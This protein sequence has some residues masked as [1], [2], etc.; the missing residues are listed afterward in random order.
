MKGF[1]SSFLGWIVVV[2]VAIVV[3]VFIVWS[4]VPDIIANNLSKKLKVSVEID[5]ISLSFNQIDVENLEVSNVPGGILQKAFSTEQILV[6]APLSRYLDNKIEIDEIDLNNVYLGLEFESSKSTKGNWTTIMNN[7]NTSES[8]SPKPKKEEKKGE[9][10]SV[11]IRTL[12]LTNIQVD[13]VYVKDGTPV[14]RLPPIDRIVLKNISSEEGVP[15][16]QIMKSVLGQMLQSVFMKQ[17]LQNMLEGI[18][19]QPQN[20]F[21][22]FL[23]PFKGLFNSRVDADKQQMKAA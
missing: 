5:D 21:D 2:I 11:F 1:L 6:K 4:R 20:S 17:N 7:L 16:D 9:G 12:I 14:K 15:M 8:S 23:Q 22:K 3:V 13:V 19:N 18:L 10:R